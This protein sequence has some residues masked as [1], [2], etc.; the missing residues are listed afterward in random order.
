M[1]GALG[2]WLRRRVARPVLDQL[3]RGITPEKIALTIA[4]GALLGIFPILGS[5]TLLCFAAAAALGLNQPI[6][7]LVNYLVYP[8]QIPLIYVFVRL[9]ERI[10]GADRV[11]FD[12]VELTAL[13]ASDPLAFLARFGATALHGILGWA[14]VAIPSIP[15]LHFV[16]VPLLRRSARRLVPVR[17]EEPRR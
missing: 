12:I 17:S 1:T 8:L 16:L 13:F 5:T 9:G 7:Q 4:L 14:L 3:R 10:A 2:A 6:V 15:L 11:A